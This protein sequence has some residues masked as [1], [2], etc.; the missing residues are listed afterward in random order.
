MIEINPKTGE[1]VWQFHTSQVRTPNSFYTPFQGSAQKLANGN[2]LV[3]STLHGHLFE[4]TPEKEV[5]W[6]F[7]NP[8]SAEGSDLLY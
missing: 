8:V 2:Y 5:V 1:I 4:V 3:C 7:V 6:D